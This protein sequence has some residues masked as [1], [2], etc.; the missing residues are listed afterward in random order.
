MTPLQ[1]Q[2]CADLIE[3]EGIK[4]DLRLAV[5]APVDGRAPADPLEALAAHYGALLRQAAGTDRR[6]ES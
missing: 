5:G 4:A 1:T 6:F 2:L 3:L